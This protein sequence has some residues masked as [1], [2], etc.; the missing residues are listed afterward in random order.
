MHVLA[1][2]VHDIPMTLMLQVVLSC[3]KIKLSSCKAVVGNPDYWAISPARIFFLLWC[4]IKLI[5][6]YFP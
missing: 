2:R 4:S 6:Q 1:R 5:R 3:L